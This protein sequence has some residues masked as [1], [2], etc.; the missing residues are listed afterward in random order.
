MGSVIESAGAAGADDGQTR[1]YFSDEEERII[2]NMVFGMS[3]PD[4]GEA[5]MAAAA[6]PPDGTGGNEMGFS[7][8]DL[9]TQFGT[10]AAR[11]HHHHHSHHHGSGSGQAQ[12]QGL[13]KAAA[14]AGGSTAPAG[15]RKQQQGRRGRGPRKLAFMARLRLAI[16]LSIMRTSKAVPTMRLPQFVACGMVFACRAATAN[17]W[18]SA[19]SFVGAR[20][21]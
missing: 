9:S 14:A 13:L 19:A 12:Q 10:D 8:G 17:P 5:T 20:W 18:C 3:S 15:S 16:R 1:G 11:G 21:V 2:D 6:V 4:G 7:D